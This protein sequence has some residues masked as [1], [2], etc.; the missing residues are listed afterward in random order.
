MEALLEAM[1]KAGPP[2]WLA[3]AS[4]VL[5]V[6]LLGAIWR[7]VTGRNSEIR[8]MVAALTLSTKA[9]EAATE[10]RE[11]VTKL[12]RENHNALMLSISNLQSLLAIARS[13]RSG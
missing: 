2:F 11:E 5:N 1:L 3:S 7:M 6:A 13:K 9:I 4:L 8:E 10:D 12:M